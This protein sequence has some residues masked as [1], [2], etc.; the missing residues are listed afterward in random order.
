MSI[1]EGHSRRVSFDM[2]EE[3]GN[4]IDKLMVM[5]GK[6]AAKDREKA[7]PFKPQIHQS[8]GRGQNSGYNQRN[9]QN[10]YRSDNRL[11]SRDRGQFWQGRGRH[12]FEQTY[13]RNH[14]EN[15]RNY[16]RQNSRGEY[17]SDNYR[18]GNYNRGSNR[19][20]ERSFSK[21]YDSNRT[22]ST[23]NSRSRLGSRVST[24]SDRIRC[25]KCREYNHFMRDCPTSREERETEQLQQMFNLE[26]DQT[27]LLTNTQNNPTDLV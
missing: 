3:L 1:R 8:R 7:R 21:D 13:R 17:R 27:S 10:R 11:S 2:R 18:S 19:S 5:I 25:Y 4:R 9:Y 23:N 24:N 26:E 16:G 20:R 22:R 12:R 14:R 15:P 6:L